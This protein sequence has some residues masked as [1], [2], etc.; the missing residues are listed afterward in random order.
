[1]KSLEG[2]VAVVTGAGSGIGKAAAILLA[3][4]GVKLA[5]L[6]FS[7]DELNQSSEEIK[8][9]GGTVLPLVVDVSNPEQMQ[10]AIQQTGDKFG[11]IDF[12]FANAG[13]N[14][15]L[16]P[17]EDL[18]PDEWDKILDTNLKGTFLTV[19]YAVPFLK[20]Q[21]G[22]VVITASVNGTRNFSNTGASAYSSSKAGQVAFAKMIAL[23]LAEWKIRVNAICP[24]A[25]RTNIET[26]TEHRNTDE[27]KIPVE[28]PEKVAALEPGTAEDVAELVLFLMSDSSKHISGSEI[29]IDAG[30]SLLVG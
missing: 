5:A 8:Q 3:K 24:G 27:I 30:G 10:K 1:M 12:V 7:Q 25:I 6:D 13:I 2:R 16:A 29:W 9:N 4:Q 22:A 15:V 17:L 19:K 26:K 18:D 23:E 28:F 21:G 11:R 20:K 14:G